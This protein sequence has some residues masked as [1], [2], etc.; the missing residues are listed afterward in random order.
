VHK[1][2]S[3]IKLHND[4]SIESQAQT[5]T[6]HGDLHVTGNVSD[7]HNSLADLRAH[8]NEHVHPP[9]GAAASPSD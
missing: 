8:Y 3:F 4:G 7:S 2:G 6:H 5:W 1:S 9:S